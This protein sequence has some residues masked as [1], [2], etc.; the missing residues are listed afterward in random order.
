MR[1]LKYPR[2][3]HL[4]FSEGA[5]SDDVVLSSDSIFQGKEIVTTLKL[6]GEN[7]TIYSDGFVHSRSIDSR[8][9]PSRSWIKQFAPRIAFELPHGWR[10]CGENLF[11]YHS[12]LYAELPS[13]FFVFAIF[14]ENNFCISWDELEEFCCLLSMSVVPVLYRGPWD[15]EAVRN[16]RFYNGPFP[17]F[18]CKD[19]V[20][21]LTSNFEP[22]T[23]EGFVVRNSSG[24][25]YE[26]FDKNVA[27]FVIENHVT[28]DEHWMDRE[29]YPNMLK[30][31]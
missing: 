29:P 20:P 27:K 22:C 1:R 16:T 9:H 2:T 31:V 26:D 23:N 3:S 10:V 4:S 25:A 8:H 15:E 7:T 13:Y 6:D 17:T 24:F 14:D 11:A 5:S 12:I 21:T 19:K 28:S 18:R 30:L